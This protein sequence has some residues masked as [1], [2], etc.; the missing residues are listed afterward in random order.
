M[1]R[2]GLDHRWLSKRDATRRVMGGS[3]RSRSLTSGD[4]VNVDVKPQHGRAQHEGHPRPD[5]GDGEQDAC[6]GARAERGSALHEGTMAGQEVP[7]RQDLD[8]PGSTMSTSSAG[9][10]PG[11]FLVS[12][13]L[14]ENNPTLST[15]PSQGRFCKTQIFPTTF[16]QPLREAETH[17]ATRCVPWRKKSRKC[18]VVCF[19]FFL[20]G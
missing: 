10:F 4:F 12:H 20:Q 2:E 7:Q 14:K 15:L 19:F 17:P 1:P 6:R 8:E 9:C 5:D 11:S 16:L 18:K 3:A 13:L